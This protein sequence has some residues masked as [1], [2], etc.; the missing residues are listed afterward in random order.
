MENEKL[1]KELEIRRH[2]AEIKRQHQEMEIKNKK[3]IR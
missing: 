3:L 1:K 2:E